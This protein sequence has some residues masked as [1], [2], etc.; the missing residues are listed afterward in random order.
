M[1][2]KAGAGLA[3]GVILL[4]TVFSFE[5]FNSGAQ[6]VG[7]LQFA[8]GAGILIGPLITAR[9]VA[10]QIRRA[11]WTI[12][13][14]F[15]SIGVSYVFFGLVPTLLL[16]MVFVFIAHMNWGSNWTL[17]SALLQRLIPDYIRGRIFSMDLG[18]VTL[19]LALSTF[20]TGIAVDHYD[21]R[22]VAIALGVVFVLFGTVWTIAGILSRQRAP[23]RWEE[24]SM[25]TTVLPEEI[26][27]IG[28]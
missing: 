5:V 15:V 20:V 7:L 25:N 21:P 2:V 8:R 10:G 12:A 3:G 27:A 18:M 22:W 13:V 6:G 11:E 9:I 24:G 17:S 4:L 23:A 14:G 16:G 1:L 26:G 19:T 28:E